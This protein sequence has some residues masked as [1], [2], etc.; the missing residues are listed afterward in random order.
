M[1]VLRQLTLS[2]KFL[3]TN[4]DRLL[5]AKWEEMEEVQERSSW[6]SAKLI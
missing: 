3:I 2:F 5:E 6:M 4:I 1:L